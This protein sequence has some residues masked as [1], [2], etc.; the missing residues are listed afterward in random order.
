MRTILALLVALALPACATTAPEHKAAVA[1]T[2][3]DRITVG[4]VQREIRI[5][6]P[7]SD[8]VEI[9]GS[10]NMVTTDEKRRETWVYDKVATERAYSTSSGGLMLLFGAIGDGVGGGFGGSGSMKSGASSVSQRTLTIIIK[11]DRKSRVRD[12][13]YR[14]SSF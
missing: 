1:D 4:K 7:S 13:S 14:T 6:M 5:G 10:P 3:G 8:V 9:L 2:T 12:Y 11:F